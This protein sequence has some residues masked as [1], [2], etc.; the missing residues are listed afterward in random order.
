MSGPN[1]PTPPPPAPT[2]P[3]PPDPPSE[4]ELPIPAGDAQR[5]LSTALAA[6]VDA[7]SHVEA[8]SMA[9]ARALDAT[10][11]RVSP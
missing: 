1:V 9:M 6:L 5:A 2:E 3:L 11:C 4:P 10:A 7:F 8:V